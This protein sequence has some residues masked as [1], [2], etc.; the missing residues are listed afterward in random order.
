MARS[1]LQYFFS[2]LPSPAAPSSST[3]SNY[4][5]LLAHARSEY[6][7]LR[8]RYL[9]SP[10]GG[11]VNDGVGTESSARAAPKAGAGTTKSDVTVNNPLGLDSSNPW[12]TWFAD[13]ELR[14]TIRQDVE[15][16]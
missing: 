10:D 13:L 7:E 12:S 16:T 8:D 11:W 5:L 2:L 4:S 3:S 9:R 15:R 6:A 14:R 1:S